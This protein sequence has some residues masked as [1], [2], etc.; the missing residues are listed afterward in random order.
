[1]AKLIGKGTMASFL[2]PLH[3]CGFATVLLV[4]LLSLII[5]STSISQILEH[6]EARYFGNEPFFN[7]D[8]IRRNDIKKIKSNISTKR[9]MDRVRKTGTEHYYEFDRKGRLQRQYETYVHHDTVRDTTFIDYSYDREGRVERVR[10]NDLHGF[11]AYEYEYDSLGRVV[12]ERYLRIENE[13]PSRYAFNPG[14]RYIIDT[15]TYQD[16][17]RRMAG[18]DPENAQIVELSNPWSRQTEFHASWT[19]PRYH[20]VQIGWQQ[21]LQEGRTTRDWITEQRERLEDGDLPVGEQRDQRECDQQ[22]GVRPERVPDVSEK[23]HRFDGPDRENQRQDG[24]DAQ[25]GDV[26]ANEGERSS[27][28]HVFGTDPVPWDRTDVSAY[29]ADRYKSSLR[30]NEPRRAGETVR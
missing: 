21:A 15:E 4:I 16:R 30:R 20:T 1:M 19:S 13:G 17:V 27:R 5:P 28:G 2:A 10:R 26:P 24:G 11:F 3:R 9:E 18:D 29:S 7:E 6:P 8:F 25:R 22:H 12:E 14:E 23:Q